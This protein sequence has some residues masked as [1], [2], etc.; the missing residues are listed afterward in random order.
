MAPAFL[1]GRKLPEA[2][3]WVIP[4]TALAT[5]LLSSF[6]VYLPGTFWLLVSVSV[7]IAGG[8][9][10]SSRSGS[11]QADQSWSD[12]TAVTEQV[13][14]QAQ[15]PV[16]KKQT[17]KKA[18]RKKS[19]TPKKKPAK[20]PA[21]NP[22]PQQQQLMAQLLDRADKLERELDEGATSAPKPTSQW[23]N[24]MDALGQMLDR[25]ER[26]EQRVGV[27]GDDEPKPTTNDEGLKISPVE[28]SG[29]QPCKSVE[30]V[31]NQE[32]IVIS[33]ELSTPTLPF[34]IEDDDDDDMDNVA[35]P[36]GSGSHSGSGNLLGSSG[37]LSLS[38]RKLLL[39]H[40]H[41]H[42]LS[43]TLK[44]DVSNK[45]LSLSAR[46]LLLHGA[47]DEPVQLDSERRLSQPMQ[48][49][50]LASREKG[51]SAGTIEGLSSMF[52]RQAASARL[53]GVSEPTGTLDFEDDQSLFKIPLEHFAISWPTS[54][55]E[56]RRIL[57]SLSRKKSSQ[58]P[59]NA[60]PTAS[61]TPSSPVHSKSTKVPS[62]MR[63]KS[64]GSPEGIGVDKEVRFNIEKQDAQPSPTVGTEAAVSTMRHSAAAYVPTGYVIPHSHNAQ[65]PQAQY[66]YPQ[67][68]Y[69][70]RPQHHKQYQ[71]RRHHHKPQDP[72]ITQAT[73]TIKQYAKRK[74]LMGAIRTME[75]A[76]KQA[77]T[78]NESGMVGL[79]NSLI[80]AAIRC[81]NLEY[82]KAVVQRMTALGLSPNTATFNA[83]ISGCGKLSSMAE[84]FA[85]RDEMQ[86]NNLA[87]DVVTYNA[88]MDA[89]VRANDLHTANKLF[90]EMVQMQL[91]PNHITYST[92]INGYSK[93]PNLE[94][95]FNTLRRMQEAGICPNQVTYTSLIDTC[96]RSQ[97]FP[98]VAVMLDEMARHNIEVN[99]YTFNTIISGCAR[100]AMITEAQHFFDAMCR[101]QVQPNHFTYNALISAC[102]NAGD[103]DEAFKTREKM[104][105]AGLTPDLCTSNTLIKGCIQVKDVDKA[106]KILGDMKSQGISPDQ[107]TYTQLID[108]CGQCHRMELAQNVLKEMSEAGLKPD[109]IML[110]ALI[111]GY[112]GDMNVAA[113]LESLS[114]LLEQQRE[115]VDWY[116]VKPV[117]DCCM[118]HGPEA[119]GKLL[120]TF[121]EALAK[122]AHGKH[123]IEAALSLLIDTCRHSELCMTEM[124]EDAMAL[125]EQYGFSFRGQ[126]EPH[127][128]A[129]PAATS[130]SNSQSES[131][132]QSL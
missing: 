16:P 40:Q 72:V 130:E 67:A 97:D 15:V 8:T 47:R 117:L 65:Y 2:G 124:S 131:I 114:Q 78:T 21:A 20:Q 1:E 71:P 132:S 74:D 76:E 111:K 9:Y 82:A 87:P 122:S 34:D 92:L 42:E 23:D 12:S 127:N 88:L 69:H 123:A 26:L 25:I 84:A 29:E 17:Q 86:A 59:K 70:A 62:A 116:I 121:K 51:M 32:S 89:C 98:R 19:K 57:R 94:M 39:K 50:R 77:D 110:S 80:G 4:A 24:T 28:V 10:I 99:A 31:T 3:P 6:L 95:A 73:A 27:L 44:A 120:D 90:E 100:S 106:F 30:V 103:V 128:V 93:I 58:M 63:R 113:M 7:G 43:N 126:N 115:K 85:T 83:L 102:A 54:N 91:V 56:L 75:M 68:Q 64:K 35:S 61:S 112:A 33:P 45:S 107:I 22:N 49:P 60:P 13:L 105:A 101:T 104:I 37:M 5:L 109:W 48:R 79:Y 36:R 96:M 18:E 108:G 125:L 41:E 118:E 66:H 14:E 129:I 52:L 53:H 55:F 38:A 46:K 119:M 81:G 11:S